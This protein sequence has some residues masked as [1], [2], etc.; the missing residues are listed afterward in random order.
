MCVLASYVCHLLSNISSDSSY[1]FMIVRQTSDR[2]MRSQADEKLYIKDIHIDRQITN[3]AET[4]TD[5]STSRQT[6][7]QTD[8]QTRPKRQ[9]I[10]YN[11]RISNIL[12]RNMFYIM[13]S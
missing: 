7:R 3:K 10:F 1:D 6:D 5:R 11:F 4:L 2:L 9:I 13:E 8:R 12:I